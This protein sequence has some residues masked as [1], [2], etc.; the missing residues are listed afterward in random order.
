MKQT[1]L[2]PI[3]PEPWRVPPMSAVRSKNGRLIVKAD[4]DAGLAAYQEAVRE[5]LVD[6]QA[7]LM[8]PPYLLKFWFW[9]KLEKNAKEVD[10]TN[11]QKALEDALQG[12]V[13]NNDRFVREIS[14]HAVRQDATTPGMILI[15]AFSGN[16][17][18]FTP[19]PEYALPDVERLEAMLAPLNVMED[20]RFDNSWP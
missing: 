16:D 14:S 3:N 2:L 10:A 7:Q 6:K 9:R 17:C 13:I 18:K 4:R 20:F 11:M 8:D 19:I 15:Q 12:I 5:E 1:F